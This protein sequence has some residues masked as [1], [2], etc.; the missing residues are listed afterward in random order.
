MVWN[1]RVDGWYDMEK[2][3]SIG[4]VDWVLWPPRHDL[5]RSRDS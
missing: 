1:V 2:D 5:T 4:G 3:N